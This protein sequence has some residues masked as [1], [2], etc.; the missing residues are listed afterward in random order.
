MTYEEVNWAKLSPAAREVHNRLRQVKGLSPLPPP[1]VDLYVAP[2][3]PQIR[4]IVKDQEYVGA[5]RDGLGP[6]L[7]A[8]GEEGFKING[9]RS[10]Y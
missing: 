2:V 5:I 8:P 6:V 3:K 4:P 10:K 7:M 1:A 9:Q